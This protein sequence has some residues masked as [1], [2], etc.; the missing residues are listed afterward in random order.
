MHRHSPIAV[1]VVSLFSTA[2]HAQSK[3]DPQFAAGVAA[4]KAGDTKRAVSQFRQVLRKAPSAKAALYLGVALLKLDRLGPAKKAFEKALALGPSDAKRTAILGLIQSIV[5]RDVATVNLKSEPPGATVFVDGK[6]SG[7]TP[8]ALSLP[9]GLRKLRVE[10]DG[11][12]VK[13]RKFKLRYGR[14]SRLN[15]RLVAKPCELTV[16]TVASARVSVDGKRGVSAAK[17]IR[18]RP[19]THR[20]QVSRK[21]Y[22]TLAEKVECNPGEALSLNAAL[23]PATGRVNMPLP[24]G[25][26]VSI[27]GQPVEAV[28][29]LDETG[30]RLPPGEHTLLVRAPG[31]EPYEKTVTV[32]AGGEVDL[33]LPTPKPP[34]APR[35]RPRIKLARKSAFYVG[36]EGSWNFVLRKWD[37]GENAFQSQDG[38]TFFAPGSSAL[39]GLRVGYQPWESL[40]LETEIHYVGLPNSI[41]TSTGLTYGVNALYQFLDDGRVKPFVQGGAGVYHVVAGALGGQVDLRGHVGVGVRGQLSERFLLR[42]DLRNVFTDGFTNTGNNVEFL[43]GLEMRW[44]R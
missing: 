13:E 32:P 21:H 12:E 20:I 22:K 8:I 14:E 17:T 34:A 10:H 41:D 36:V 2:S 23:T 3:P 28:G 25:A 18:L 40:S 26:M 11:Y 9:S 33:K 5:E 4:Y 38:M 42:A 24:P 6:A 44:E 35:A 31:Q 7:R 30:M 37:L 16:E 43:T 15:V 19:G 1:V 39:G 27:N 29:T